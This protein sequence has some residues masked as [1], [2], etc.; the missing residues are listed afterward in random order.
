M[1]DI[2]LDNIKNITITS[3]ASTPRVIVNEVIDTLNNIDTAD[4]KTKIELLDYI[5]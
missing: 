4:F 1:K 3:A 2:N 5:K